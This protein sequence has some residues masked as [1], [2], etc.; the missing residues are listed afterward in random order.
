MCLT[1]LRVEPHAAAVDS[2]LPSAR[3][4][5]DLACDVF[6]GVMNPIDESCHKRRQRK[7]LCR[8]AGSAL[9]SHQ[10]ATTPFD[11]RCGAR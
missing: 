11:F 6:L 4:I 5:L 8:H 3:L 7:R 1:E 10:A 9:G 2:M